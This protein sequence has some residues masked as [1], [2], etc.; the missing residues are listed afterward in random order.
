MIA[1]ADISGLSDP[2]TSNR[3]FELSHDETRVAIVTLDPRSGMQDIWIR[4][5]N[6]G[7]ML[8]LT[9]H[10]AH[11]GAPVWSPD[12]RRLAYGSTRDGRVAIFETMASG[13]DVERLLF[14]GPAVPFDWSPDGRHLVL[15]H[16]SARTQTDLVLV[17]T[18]ADEQQRKPV[19][20]LDTPAMEGEPQ[21]SP[22]GRWMAYSST[23]SGARQIFVEPIPRS[24]AR[25]QISSGQA[26]EPRWRGDGRELFYL[27]DGNALMSVAMNLAGNDWTVGRPESLFSL[28]VTDRDVRYHYAVSSDGNRFLVNT[29]MEDA[30]GTPINVW[31]P[32]TDPATRAAAPPPVDRLLADGTPADR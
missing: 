24:G 12:D 20:Y 7:A 11:D 26:R 6:R 3:D 28:R 5:V 22:D 17:G 9:R 30:V 1:P 15:Q 27:G 2:P 19:A 29:V 23:N 10:P 18:G 13:A 31:M 4:D 16:F 25:W 32:W 14:T 8:L 21:Y